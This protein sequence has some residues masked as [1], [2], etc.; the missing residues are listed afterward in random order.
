LLEAC[1]E[2]LKQAATPADGPSMPTL[3]PADESATPAAA[4]A[5]LDVFHKNLQ[6][7]MLAE[8]DIRLQPVEG[9]L[10]ALRAG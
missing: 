7:V 4:D 1:F 8:L 3:A 9:L 5:W 2:R 6:S 10:K